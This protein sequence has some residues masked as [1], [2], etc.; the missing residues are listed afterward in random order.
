MTMPNNLDEFLSFDPQN[1]VLTWKHRDASKFNAAKKPA[2]ACASTWNK[3][4]AGQEA[5]N[6]FTPNGYLHGRINGQSYYTHRIIWK[7]V[8]GEEP[9]TIDHI[10][11]N[12]AD[13]RLDNLRNVPMAV[14][15]KN[16]KM[17]RSNTSGHRGVSKNKQGKWIARI[18]VNYVRIHLGLF[19]NFEQAVA[20]RLKAEKDY[21]FHENH[22]RIET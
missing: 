18:K 12:K 11:G 16:M 3:R 15:S 13:N 10:N 17:F 8:H 5:F 4:F 9:D 14:N 1:G 20:A 2:E 6:Y 22:G 7:L 19:D 21:G